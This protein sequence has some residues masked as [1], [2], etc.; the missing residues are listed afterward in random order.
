MVGVWCDLLVTAAE[1][2]NNG[3]MLEYSIA[4]FHNMT[5]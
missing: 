1:L 2:I 4:G 3:A 5:M